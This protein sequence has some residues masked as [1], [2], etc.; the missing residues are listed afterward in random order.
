[1]SE[2]KSEQLSYSEVYIEIM[3][4]DFD[5][6]DDSKGKLMHI[7]IEN[8]FEE[9]RSQNSRFTDESSFLYESNLS[10]AEE[11]SNTM[12]KLTK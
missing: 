2:S 11:I 1:M 6:A 10:I 3:E 8:N 4:S 12:I 5:I 7:I 9:Q